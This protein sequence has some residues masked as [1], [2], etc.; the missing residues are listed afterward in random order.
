MASLQK[1]KSRLQTVES[2]R[3]ITHAMELVSTSKMR[4]A[5]DYFNTASLYHDQV[6][7]LLDKFLINVDASELREYWGRQLQPHQIHIILASDMGLAGSYN[8]NVLKLASQQIK[9]GDELILIGS[10]AIGA[11]AQKYQNQ[12]LFSWKWE[13]I[14][15]NI[16]ANQLSRK[17]IDRY[18]DGSIGKINVIYNKFINNLV[19]QE[20][21]EQILP[22]ERGQELNH[23]AKGTQIIDF[24]PNAHDVLVNALPIFVSAK[25]NLAFAGAIISEYAARR[26][27][28]ETATDNADELINDLNLE[29]NRKRQS[30]I[31]QELNEIVGGANAV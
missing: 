15:P 5:R 31:T 19:Q 8:S 30:N 12:V 10:K 16:I 20:C 18:I 29:Y 6:V 28:M 23:N 22:Y 9:P 2:I 25:I 26:S 7:D 17:L 14:E 24:E 4:R 3:K 1:I 27:A 11:F 13:Q 21:I